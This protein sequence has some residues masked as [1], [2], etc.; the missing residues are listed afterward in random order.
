MLSSDRYTNTGIKYVNV[1]HVLSK[2]KR[3]RAQWLDLSK[4][5][6]GLSG[7]AF[8]RFDS[9]PQSFQRMPETLD[10]CSDT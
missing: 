7:S 2:A 4:P 1:S 6:R 3:T 5:R 9:F 10:I 8:P